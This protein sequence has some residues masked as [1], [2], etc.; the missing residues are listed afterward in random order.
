MY[1]I[2]FYS[3]LVVFLI[4]SFIFIIWRN[5][6]VENYNKLTNQ[7]NQ[8][9]N[10]SNQLSNEYNKLISENA[11][12]LPPP[13]TSVYNR[14]FIIAFRKVNGTINYWNIPFDALE[15]SIKLGYLMREINP[16]K[17]Q[18]ELDYCTKIASSSVCSYT[19][20]SNFITNCIQMVDLISNYSVKY[21]SLDNN[22]VQAKVVDF[23]PFVVP[24][25]FKNVIKKL[26]EES[27]NEEEFIHETWNIVTQLDTYS[28][29]IGETP[30]YPLETFLAGGGD[31]DNTAVL[32]A[33]MIKAAPTNWDV[34]FIYMDAN[35]P[36]NPVTP[37]HLMVGIKTND[38]TYLI[39]TTQHNVM[40][41]FPKINGWWLKI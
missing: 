19:D 11:N 39:D 23:R 20:C 22:G 24:I 15:A 32:F 8:L 18:N 1:K 13:Y 14:T 27:K 4:I 35:N 25:T 26:Y 7:C 10:A 28:A 33:S 17:L 16:Q 36:E 12:K 9:L 34:E 5:V 41:P 3:L 38:R 29:V 30:R 37:N 40:E 2:L 6:T 31:C 21:I